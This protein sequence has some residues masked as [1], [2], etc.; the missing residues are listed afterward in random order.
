MSEDLKSD[1]EINNQEHT[2][3]TNKTTHLE[4]NKLES[5]RNIKNKDEMRFDSNGDEIVYEIWHNPTWWDYLMYFMLLFL[6]I[7][8][9]YGGIEKFLSNEI[10]KSLLITSLIFGIPLH[11][12]V[13][14][15]YFTHAKTAFTLPHK[16]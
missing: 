6:G 4:S 10:E 1:R 3:S 8:M 5:K 15:V 7:T 16:A 13:H 12:L 9:V 11:C 14:I 2:E